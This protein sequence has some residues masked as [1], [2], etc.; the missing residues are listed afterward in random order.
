MKSKE[1]EDL[2]QGKKTDP[3]LAAINTKDYEIVKMKVRA[4]GSENKHRQKLLP[5]GS[6]LK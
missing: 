4:I 6:E 2:K 5:S 1:L 3:E